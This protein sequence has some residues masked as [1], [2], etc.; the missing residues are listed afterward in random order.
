MALPPI[1]ELHR[2]PKIY[3]A[4]IHRMELI[5]IQLY[6]Q[7]NTKN[8]RLSSFCIDSY[9]LYWYNKYILRRYLCYLLDL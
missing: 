6:L 4:P 8:P 1:E 5:S 3:S 2:T 7:R 9:I